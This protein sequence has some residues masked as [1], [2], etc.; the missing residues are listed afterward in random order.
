[1]EKINFLLCTCLYH[2]DNWEMGY[3]LFRKV[4]YLKKCDIHCI[5]NNKPHMEMFKLKHPSSC[6]IVGPS[7]SG[8]TFLVREM[9]RNCIYDSNIKKIKWCYSHPA[10]WFLEETNFEF[11]QGLPSSYEEGDL[12][13]IDDLMHQLNEKIAE[14][15]IATSHHRS[16][17]VQILLQ[18]MF[19]R[20]KVMR[21]ISLNAHY[22]ILFK[23]AR[24]V[25]QVNCLARQLYPGNS[26]F[27]TDA[28]IKATSKPYGYLVI[29]VHPTTTEDYRL[30]EGLFPSREGYYWIFR[31]Q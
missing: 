6:L 15:C 19:P 13:I 17:S 24:D 20:L 31:P 22:I 10:P 12:I 5:S 2:L 21:D 25:S 23:N 27:L 18:N 16:I 1:M 14:L 30:R 29:D 8:K 11:I 3:R 26:K 7:Q 9:I 4:I 28:Y